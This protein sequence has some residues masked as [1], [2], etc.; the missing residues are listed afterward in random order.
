MLD[1]D[2]DGEGNSRGNTDEIDEMS[3]DEDERIAESVIRNGLNCKHLFQIG[4]HLFI[5][6]T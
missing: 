4:D 5:L 1:A 6:C 2:V 3:P